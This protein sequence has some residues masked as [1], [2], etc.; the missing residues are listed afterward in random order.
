MKKEEYHPRVIAFRK[1]WGYAPYHSQQTKH[2]DPAVTQCS[3]GAVTDEGSQLS[4]SVTNLTADSHW[5]IYAYDIP[6]MGKRK[7]I[8]GSKLNR[9]LQL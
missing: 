3:G 4:S 6:L 8:K 1:K 7:R 5:G 2:G 9:V